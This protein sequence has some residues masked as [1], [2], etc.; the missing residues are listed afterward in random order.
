MRAWIDQGMQWEKGFTFSK[1]RNAPV[2]PRRV[3]LP[4]GEA[5][6]PVDRFLSH[7]Y[8]ENDIPEV[9]PI[10]DGVFARRVFL[11]V[12]GLL[13]TAQ[14]VKTFI[15]DVRVDKRQRLVGELLE[16]R[17]YATTARALL[18]Q[19]VR[20]RRPAVHAAGPTDGAG[21]RQHL[22]AQRRLP[23]VD[24]RDDADDARPVAGHR[25]QG[26]REAPRCG[27]HGTRSSL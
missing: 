27:Q 13:P 16:D 4:E 10:E 6:N 2:A 5:D 8:R 18:G 22:L 12:L 20:R 14:E 19:E 9:S 23:G 17:D 7:Y 1:F 15:E 24:V 25:R 11:D 21:Q 3:S 26:P